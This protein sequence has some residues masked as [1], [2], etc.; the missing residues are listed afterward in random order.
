MSQLAIRIPAAYSG[1]RTGALPMMYEP[2]HFL[3]CYS[4][5]STSFLLANG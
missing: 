3:L 2:C 4:A 1:K 5:I